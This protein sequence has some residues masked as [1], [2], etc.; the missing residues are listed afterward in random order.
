M[1]TNN[2][3]RV[4]NGVEVGNGSVAT[5]SGSGL[6]LTGPSVGIIST[7]TYDID[8]YTNNF[9]ADGVE[10]WLRH[11][12]GVEINTANGANS[13]QFSNTGTLTFP[14]LTVQTSAFQGSTNTVIV[15]TITL[16][17]QSGVLVPS[18]PLIS[19]NYGQMFFDYEGGLVDLAL[20]TTVGTVGGT[21]DV[22]DNFAKFGTHSIHFN[23]GYVHVDGTVFDIGTADWTWDSW[24]YFFD[25]ES[26]LIITTFHNPHNFELQWDGASS[27]GFILYSDVDGTI[28]PV[29]A[30]LATK[31]TWHHVVVMRKDNLVYVGIDGVM[32][33]GYSMNA[34]IAT[35]NTLGWSDRSASG[36][37]FYMDM[38]RWNNSAIFPTTGYTVPTEASYYTLIGPATTSS[39]AANNIS[40]ITVQT[41]TATISH[42]VVTQ[43]DGPEGSTV[44]ATGFRAGWYASG[45]G[46]SFKDDGGYDTGMFS[47]GDGQ[48]QF[49]ANNEE[50][51]NI[52]TDRF[53]FNKPA[54]LP[55]IKIS[56]ND[57]A[58]RSS[59][60]ANLL[61]VSTGSV[62]I[63]TI[64]DTGYTLP[65]TK[66]NENQILA[67]NGSGAMTWTDSTS[68]PSGPE[69][70]QGP[71]GN[72]GPQGPTG[73]EGPQGPTGNE[74][75][76]GP[77]GNEGPQGPT[78]NEGPQGPTGNEG[79]QGPT[80]N[81]GPQGPQGDP[82][83]LAGTMSGDIDL[84]GHNL[85]GGN[86][87]GNTISLPTGFGPTIT[88]GY[89]GLV[90][91]RASTNNTDFAGWNF[92][93]DGS[94]LIPT[95]ST[96]YFHIDAINNTVT[97]DT[98]DTITFSS[99]SGEI[100]IN[101]LYNG[102]MYKFLV[103]GG[104]IWLLGSTNPNWDSPANNTNPTATSSITDYMDMT[105]SSGN[106][107]FTN[108]ASERGYSI[109]A[110]RTRA[111][112]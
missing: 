18:S 23:Y 108:L 33:S 104:Y 107:V 80:G 74:G 11:N 69:G 17:D 64:G 73:N 25:T 82:A 32:S 36:S 75:P 29:D 41:N 39:M 42:A 85:K 49:Y 37:N 61:G 59:T 47:W 106:Y 46:Y 79:P 63:G 93:S 92:N 70:P 86:Y 96:N 90:T 20:Q 50:V 9:A 76:Q 45:A 68:G 89:E 103:G 4:K 6:N 88:A 58:V 57:F 53:Q 84:N 78:G 31:D 102:Y 72:E 100:L 62:Q 55:T 77:T 110:V 15:G 13:W 24:C 3:F 19:T 60:N 66:G 109:Y 43:L 101:D 22:V 10:V 2:N 105:Y 98:D 87:S 7:S 81:E 83:S 34:N 99:F 52:N 12:Q 21:V 44:S 38:T 95:N 5:D 65:L 14:N 71:T 26:N 94:L 27:L 8:L 16:N 35:P 28:Y 67:L 48:V 91:I 30:G 1:T 54:D 51:A 112:D 40:A 97:M 56:G 111:S